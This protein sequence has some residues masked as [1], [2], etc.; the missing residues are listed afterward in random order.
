[1]LRGCAEGGAPQLAAVCELQVWTAP[2]R[3]WFVSSVIVTI[4]VPEVRRR[5][6]SAG[7]SVVIFMYWAVAGAARQK[8]STDPQASTASRDFIETSLVGTDSRPNEAQRFCCG[9]ELRRTCPN[10]RAVGTRDPS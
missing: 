7:L 9:L 4:V 1:M 6:L 8:R 10:W 2:F 5:V 3:S